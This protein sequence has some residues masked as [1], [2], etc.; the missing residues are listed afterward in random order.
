MSSEEDNLPCFGRITHLVVAEN[1]VAIVVSEYVTCYFDEHLRAYAIEPSPT[2]QW[3][4]I[5]HQELNHVFTYN[6]K[7]PYNYSGIKGQ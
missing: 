1:V 5:L 7:R 2:V 4:C 6:V 3:R